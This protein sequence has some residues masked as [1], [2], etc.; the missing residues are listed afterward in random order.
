[1]VLLI[2]IGVWYTYLYVYIIS[3]SWYCWYVPWNLAIDWMES[4]GKKSPVMMVRMVHDPWLVRFPKNFIIFGW[5]KSIQQDLFVVIERQ[6]LCSLY[7]HIYCLSQVFVGCKMLQCVFL[8]FL[9]KKNVA[10]FL[11]V[12]VPFLQNSYHGSRSPA[13][14]VPPLTRWAQEPLDLGEHTG[15]FQFVYF[16][17]IWIHMCMCLI[18]TY[19]TYVYI[20]IYTYRE[21]ES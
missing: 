11:L 10:A 16:M 13:A 17:C 1:M 3:I 8:F 18:S 14:S 20:Y 15:P 4:A 12:K 2:C 7:P 6:F 21:R 5:W 19:V 9:G